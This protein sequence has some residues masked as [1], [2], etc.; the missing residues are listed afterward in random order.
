ME[1]LDYRYEVPDLQLA[2]SKG[3]AVRKA[4]DRTQ[5]LDE[6]TK[7]MQEWADYVDSIVVGNVVEM[8]FEGAN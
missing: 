6:R 3:D 7:M 1:E 2:H 4:Y 8:K 5:F